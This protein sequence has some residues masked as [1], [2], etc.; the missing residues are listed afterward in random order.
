MSFLSRL[1]GHPE[2]KRSLTIDQLPWLSSAS[3]GTSPGVRT[4]LSIPAVYA[5]VS[6]VADTI[7]TLPLPV[8]RA[9]PVQGGQKDYIHPVYDLLNGNPNPVQTAKAY[10]ASM[11]LDLVTEGEHFSEIVRDGFGTAVELWRIPRHHVRTDWDREGRRLRFFVEGQELDGQDLLHVVSFS[12]DGIRGMSPFMLCKDALT[13]ATQMEKF[14]TSFF[15]NSARPSGILNTPPFIK[16]EDL[17]AARKHWEASQSGPENTGKTAVLPDG[18]AWTKISV[19]PEEGQF[20]ESRQQQL[21]EMQRVCRV[22]PSIV[23]DFSRQTWANIQYARM[24]YVQ[25]TIRPLV[26]AIEQEI[27]RKLIADK[28]HYVEHILEGLLRGSFSEQIDTLTKAVGG[29]IY[30]ANEARK[31]MG[32]PPVDHADALKAATPAP[33]PA[34]K[35]AN[36]NPVDSNA[37]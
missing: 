11:V 18:F 31:I 17:T 25:N 3:A 33:Q 27:N 32:L 19:D 16:P 9:D 37:A 14:G 10:R 26:V 8:Y 6:N 7:S 35:D 1:L 34:T 4:A 28:N 15:K 30:T 24:D 22:P 13:L 12:L 2:E 21:T 29:P 36:G 20:N 5:A 23:N